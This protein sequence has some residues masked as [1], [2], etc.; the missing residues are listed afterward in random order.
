MASSVSSQRLLNGLWP[1]C[2]DNPARGVH[3]KKLD[4]IALSFM[5][6]YACA[7]CSYSRGRSH[8]AWKEKTKRTVALIYGHSRH[9]AGF[10]GRRGAKGDARLRV[11][12]LF[13]LLALVVQLALPVAQTWHITAAHAGSSARDPA[14]SHLLRGDGTPLAC[15]KT[16]RIAQHAPNDPI[17]CPICQSFLRIRDIVVGQPLI[18]ATS[19]VRS[20][21]I[22]SSVVHVSHLALHASAPRAPPDLS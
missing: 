18:A 7:C 22:P 8:A 14:L 13:C 11:G 21:F 9:T 3:Q 1:R 10:P 17:L 6:C 19:A 5:T 12:T 16:D 2:Q 15:L 20:W 4:D